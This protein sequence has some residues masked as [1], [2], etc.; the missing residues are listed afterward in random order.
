[1]GKITYVYCPQTF[2]GWI[3]WILGYACFFATLWVIYQLLS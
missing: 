2:S 1:M 3:G